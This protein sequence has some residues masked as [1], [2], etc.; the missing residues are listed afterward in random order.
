M[1]ELSGICLLNPWTSFHINLLREE[2]KA[3]KHDAYSIF[4]PRNTDIVKTQKN[5][6]VILQVFF[7]ENK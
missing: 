1:V 6:K 7:S 3:K 5:K 2:N 4:K